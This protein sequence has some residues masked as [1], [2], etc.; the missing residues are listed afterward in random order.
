MTVFYGTT[1]PHDPQP[2]DLWVRDMSGPFEVWPEFAQESSRMWP[3]KEPSMHTVYLLILTDGAGW[4]RPYPPTYSREEV[5]FD[6]ARSR[7]DFPAARGM[8]IYGGS[9]EHIEN[10]YNQAKRGV[11][12]NGIIPDENG[13]R[14]AMEFQPL[15]EQYPVGRT[16]SILDVW[17]TRDE[18]RALIRLMARVHSGE[19]GGPND[20]QDQG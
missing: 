2:G 17:L 20:G 8:V 16:R 11:T 4:F 6:Y 13:M 7:T 10:I 19:L 18:L 14:M 1:P 15:R 9:V 5:F 3:S 12:V